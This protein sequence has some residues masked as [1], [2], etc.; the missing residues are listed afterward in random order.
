VV[1]GQHEIRA[2]GQDL[3]QHAL[4]ELLAAHLLAGQLHEAGGVAETAAGGLEFAHEEIRA[5]QQKHPGD[6]RAEL[7]VAG[8]APEIDLAGELQ[9]L[10][11]DPVQFRSQPRVE[12]VEDRRE[13]PASVPHL[14]AGQH[15]QG[16]V[17][18]IP[19]DPQDPGIATPF[20]PHPR[21]PG[22]G[23]LGID[24]GHRPGSPGQNIFKSRPQAGPQKHGQYACGRK[25]GHA[26][27]FV[28][29]PSPATQMPHAPLAQDAHIQGTVLGA[30]G[31]DGVP[32]WDG[33]HD[34]ALP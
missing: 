26:T 14:P 24:N 34:A 30:K 5:G 21:Q 9:P 12:G 27:A 11:Q 1:D 15:G 18:V 22:D 23:L 4:H 3:G 19:V 28:L 20:F 29:G 31:L 7:G 32:A 17:R 13:G 16:G 8:P 33:G 2:E 6:G 25:A 10:G